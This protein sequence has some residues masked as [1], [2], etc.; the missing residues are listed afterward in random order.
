MGKHAY[1]DKMKLDL[2]FAEGFERYEHLIERKR[3]LVR[4]FPPCN[5]NAGFNSFTPA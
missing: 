3:N 4:A 2:P 5:S 1:D